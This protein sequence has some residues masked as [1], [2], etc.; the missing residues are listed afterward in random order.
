MTMSPDELYENM[1]TADPFFVFA[2]PCVVESEEHAL[3]VR[4]GHP[5]SFFPSVSCSLQSGLI[6][7]M[8]H[9]SIHQT[10]SFF[11]FSLLFH[12]TFSWVV[13]AKR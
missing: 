8:S 10:C 12:L 4:H 2:G 5:S 11:F 3:K 9:D 13:P 1:T 7:S 6:S